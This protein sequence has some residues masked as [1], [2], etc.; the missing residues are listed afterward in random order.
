MF[1]GKRGAVA[2]GH[3]LT[4]D[5]AISILESGGNAFDAVVAATAAA[6][7][8]EPV[9]ASPGGGGFLTARPADGK[10]LVYDFFVQTPAT[11]RP[12][13]ESD[14]YP[15]VV[16][17]GA[18]QQEFHIGTAAVATPGVVKGLFTIHENHGAMPIRECFSP[19]IDAARN[20]VTLNALQAYLNDLIS[21][22]LLASEEAKTLFGNQSGAI[23]QE[24]DTQRFEQL[25]DMLDSLALE[26]PDLFYRGKVSP[27]IA[28]QCEKG[29]HW[30][31]RN[32]QANK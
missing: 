17:F 5:A 22:I 7:V 13:D 28:R 4:A 21:P 1:S 3:P 8:C 29:G 25:A 2:A 31:R 9:L 20:G 11:P 18:T 19:A 6:F 27:A 15:I 12:H 30:R 32:L 23:L 14:F 24:G 16:D 26:G 10:P